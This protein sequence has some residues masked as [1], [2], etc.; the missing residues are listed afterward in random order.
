MNYLHL[1]IIK[2]EIDHMA[3]LSVEDCVGERSP[4]RLLRQINKLMVSR[5]ALRFARTELSFPQWLALKLVNDGVVGTPGELARELDM[6]SGAT[7]RLIDTLEE[8]GLLRRARTPGDR[9]M[10][11]LMISAGGARALLR[12]APVIAGS[13]NEILSDFAD[14]E[15]ERLIDLLTLLQSRLR[16]H[17]A[18]APS[19]SFSLENA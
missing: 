18:P 14:S 4:G 5:V 15:F 9:R 7:T 2:M 12:L 1:N 11:H 8:Q 13:W 3:H 17:D 19:S 10:I 6:T 16:R